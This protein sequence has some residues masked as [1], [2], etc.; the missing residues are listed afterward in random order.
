MGRAN[1]EDKERLTTSAFAIAWLDVEATGSKSFISFS[2]GR[3]YA[4]DH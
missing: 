1:S 2:F 3:H 4:V